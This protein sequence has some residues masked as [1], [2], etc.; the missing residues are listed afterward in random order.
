MQFRSR[1]LISLLPTSAVEA[2]L[3]S[4]RISSRSTT[5]MLE[6]AFAIYVGRKHSVAVPNARL[7]SCLA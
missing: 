7:G 2:L 6:R 3:C 4:Q 5:E 1:I